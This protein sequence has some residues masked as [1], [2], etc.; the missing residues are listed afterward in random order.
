MECVI[1]NLACS[2][3]FRRYA[4]GMLTHAGDHADDKHNPHTQSPHNSHT[5][6]H[7]N[8]KANHDPRKIK[9]QRVWKRKKPQKKKN[10]INV[11][12]FCCPLIELENV[13]PKQ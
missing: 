12:N 6:N 5:V 10:N 9:A 8:N 4:M 2:S 3:H 13:L 1:T 11:K 7:S